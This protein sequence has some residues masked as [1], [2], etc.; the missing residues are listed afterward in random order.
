MNRPKILNYEGKEVILSDMES[1]VAESLQRQ[2]MMNAL[3]FEIELL[4]PS[5]RS[6]KK[7]LSSCFIKFRSLNTFRCA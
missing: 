2:L 6:S 4:R 1:K 5:R 3:G 7:S